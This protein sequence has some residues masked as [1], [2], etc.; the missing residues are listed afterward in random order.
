MPNHCW[1]NVNMRNIG[2]NEEFYTKDK[3]GVTNFD[4]QKII[5]APKDLYAPDTSTSY[6][7]DAELR[8]VIIT[9]LENL[10]QRDRYSFIS[11]QYVTEKLPTIEAERKALNEYYEKFNIDRNDVLRIGLIRF[12]NL[13]KHGFVSWYEFCINV[14]GTKWNAWDT[15]IVDDDNVEFTTAWGPPYGIFM[16]I[17]EM[18]PYDLI[19]VNWSEEGGHNGLLQF[20]SGECIQ[21]IEYVYDQDVY[22]SY[23]ELED[24]RDKRLFTRVELISKGETNEE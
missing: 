3:E 13:V 19:T 7:Y 18:Y 5:P 16:K 8:E 23:E 9:A 4:F 10:V 15:F 11:S 17:S 14:W 22:A 20:H 6:A 1:N 21:D 2:K 24:A 12:T